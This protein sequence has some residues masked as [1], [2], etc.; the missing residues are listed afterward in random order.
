[1]TK[2]Q[3]GLMTGLWMWLRR[4]EQGPVLV[5]LQVGAADA[6]PLNSESDF[7]CSRWRGFGHLLQTDVAT[8]VEAE[9]LHVSPSPGEV[10]RCLLATQLSDRDTTVS[11]T[12]LSDND[13][14]GGGAQMPDP[15]RGLL[16]SQAARQ[17]APE[18][19]ALRLGVGWTR[20]DLD[21]PHVLVE[22]VAGDSHPGSVH[23]SRA[24]E[25][26]VL[27]A[28]R[29]GGA[30]ARYT[31]TDMCDGIAQGTDGM[32]YSLLSRDLIAGVTEM[33]ARSGHFDAVILISSCDKA[34]PAHLMAAARLDLPAV[35]VPGGSMAAGRGDVT[36]D[37]IGEISA[38]MRRGELT[39]A[40]YRNWADH[41]VP[42]CG[43]C[44]FM[45]TALTSQAASEVL[46]L[47][48]PGSAVLPAAGARLTE[49]AEQ[50]AELVLGHLAAG[51]TAR[52]MLTPASL[53]NAM[54]VHAA[55][56]GST[57]FLLH[58]P[59][60]AGELDLDVNLDRLQEINNRVPFLL[61]T[62]P[63]GRLPANLFWH[64]GGVRRVMWEVRDHLDLT[65]LAATG[66]SWGDE[67]EAWVRDGGLE[68][69]SATLNRRGLT[70]QDVIRP[71]ERPLDRRGA[72]AVLHGNLAPDSAIVKRSAVHPD[73]R[74]LEGRAIV[75]EDQEGALAAI[76]AGGVQ[77]GHVLVIRNEG[78][79]GSG[80]PEQYYV[81]SAV[82]ADKN[83]SSSTAI[84][85]DGRFSGASKG[86]CIG[87]VS[88]E[89]AV[90]GPIAAVRD[91]DYILVDID[92]GILDLIGEEGD[93]AAVLSAE[94]G[95]RILRARLSGWRP[96][97]PPAG[98]SVLSLYRSLASSAVRGAVLRTPRP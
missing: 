62:R 32:D 3:R 28:R 5:L 19:E 25:A 92:H 85:T 52:D 54:V 43:A 59:A 36:V 97:S 51:R 75:F 10:S 47:A 12:N 66:R 48:P 83:L 65:A 23:L 21:R 18:A 73:A 87:H 50:A 8:T 93:D 20:E 14:R 46:G 70:A 74:R 45:G 61:D 76:V 94:H 81:T 86:P 26:A 98:T 77:P 56:G 7:V 63:T 69:P 38:K 80:M 84:V 34:V 9:R 22:A 1:M 57:N 78:P 2:Y 71:R 58:L 15:S 44:A 24:V 17:A 37:Q 29:A 68:R 55:I 4:N 79:R 88:P 35:H 13:A 96:D 40:E 16:R 60:L 41:A 39:V 53:D 67:L 31:C 49:V 95:Q 89:A 82:A 33:H 11:F 42:S 64:A 6:T 91:G 72:V 27:A 90:G 30:P